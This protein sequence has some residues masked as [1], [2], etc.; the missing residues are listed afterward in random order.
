MRVKTIKFS[1]AGPASIT[2]ELSIEEAAA[3]T[4]VFGKMADKE[5][6]P[7]L[8]ELYS[9]MTGV[10]FNRHWDNGVDGYFNGDRAEGC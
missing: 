3:L 4:K 2:L 8:R 9:K 6:P 5:T 10:V 7:A 1:D